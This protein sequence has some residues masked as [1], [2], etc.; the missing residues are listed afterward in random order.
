MLVMVIFKRKLNTHVSF[1]LANALVP[2]KFFTLVRM[3]HVLEMTSSKSGACS[4]FRHRLTWALGVLSIL[5]ALLI[6]KGCSPCSLLTEDSAAHS[7]SDRLNLPFVLKLL[8]SDS[9]TT[10]QGVQYIC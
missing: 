1:S 10:H 3:T 6:N 8:S 7:F 5:S 4:T 2:L 9:D